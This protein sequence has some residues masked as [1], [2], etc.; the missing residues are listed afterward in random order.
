MR[1][2]VN[3]DVLG[4]AFFITDLFGIAAYRVS[5]VIDCTVAVLPCSNFAIKPTGMANQRQYS[6][7]ATS[8]IDLSKDRKETMPVRPPR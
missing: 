6:G 7:Q 5:P 1:W 3:D 4:Q 2:L 8:R